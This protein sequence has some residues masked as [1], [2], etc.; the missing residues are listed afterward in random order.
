MNTKTIPESKVIIAPHFS[1]FP[2]PSQPLPTAIAGGDDAGTVATA[3]LEAIPSTTASAA[4]LTPI[5]LPWESKGRDIVQSRVK[6]TA[7]DITLV[8]SNRMTVMMTIAV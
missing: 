1:I 3:I 6:A 5:I 4:A 7:L 8:R 2:F